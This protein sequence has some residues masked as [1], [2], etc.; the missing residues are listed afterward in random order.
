MDI[1]GKPFMASGGL[2]SIKSKESY[3]KIKCPNC[4]FIFYTFYEPG[5]CLAIVCT[6]C[7]TKFMGVVNSVNCGQCEERLKCIGL[8]PVI[9]ELIPDKERVKITPDNT[10]MPAG[11]YDHAV[12]ACIDAF[13]GITITKKC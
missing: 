9:F 10:V 1:K 5:S 6:V 4:E 3:C 8:K 11:F 7:Y 2:T 13:K 12:G